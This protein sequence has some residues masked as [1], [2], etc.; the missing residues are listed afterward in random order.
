MDP[1]AERLSRCREHGERT[2]RPAPAQHRRPLSRGD[3]PA[4]PRG[5]PPAGQ[6]PHQAAGRV[7]GHRG[8]G[9]RGRR[10]RAERPRP[11]ERQGGD[12][13]GAPG[14]RR[15]VRQAP[16]RRTQVR[17]LLA[18]N[19][20]Q[21]F[22]VVNPGGLTERCSRDPPSP[23]TRRSRTHCR[24]SGPQPSAT[25]SDSC[26][27][28]RTS[29][30]SARSGVKSERAP[31]RD[32]RD[33]R[34]R[35]IADARRRICCH[36]VT[37]PSSSPSSSRSSPRCSPMPRP[38][39]RTQL[40]AQNAS[41][42]ESS[43]EPVHR[44]CGGGD[45]P[46]AAAGVRPLVVAD[47]PDSADRL[48]V[49]GDRLGRLLRARRRRQPRRARCARRQR[50][51]DERRAPAPL[52]G[53]RDDEP[54]QVGVPGEHVARAAD[55]AERDHRLLAG[56]ARADVRRRSTPKQEEYVDDILSSG[57]HLLVA[58]QRRSRPVEGRGRAGG[59]RGRAVLAA[60]GARERR[61]DGARAGDEGRRPGRA[62]ERIARST[63]SRATSDGSGR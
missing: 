14:T 34:R 11:V 63:W 50:Q 18:E 20:G 8:A 24:E 36:S 35:A 19:V 56:A 51:P 32:A 31:D 3:N 1:R 23:S 48:A 15:R 59:A 52:P 45:R 41:A 21:D 60:R 46:R 54:A 33:R 43:R 25:A 30:S 13:R 9:R 4:R 10:A 12:A 61:R 22:Y 58:D 27:Q 42:Y 28:P 26:L 57:N 39:R 47:R 53:A 29:G 2:E 40:I 49:G 5:R 16:E 62:R 17:L 55:A 37:G 7:R 38:R 44:R 6:G